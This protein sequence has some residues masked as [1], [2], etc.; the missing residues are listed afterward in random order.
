MRFSNSFFVFGRPW[1][2][3]WTL[4][5]LPLHCL[6]PELCKL[7]FANH[8]VQVLAYCAGHTVQVASLSVLFRLHCAGHTMQV[9][10]CRPYC[11]S[12]NILCR[13]HCASL[14]TLCKSHCAGL[15]VQVLAHCASLKRLCKLHCAS[16]STLSHCALLSTLCKLHCA[17]HT[18]NGLE[19][20]CDYIHLY[21]PPKFGITWSK[22]PETG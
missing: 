11:A 6:G 1:S 19:R 3:P 21:R 17:G 8:T 10:L 22:Q 20:L 13:L 15:T 9:T 4:E 18:R 16:L 2:P 14:S 12:L 5:W 7:Q